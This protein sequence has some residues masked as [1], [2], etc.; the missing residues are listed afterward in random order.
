MLAIICFT[1]SGLP[2][3]CI[4]DAH[5]V[6]ITLDKAVVHLKV[7]P[8]ISDFCDH[9]PYFPIKLSSRSRSLFGV[10]QIF[11]QYTSNGDVVKITQAEKLVK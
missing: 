8:R 11:E 6:A 3:H 1:S 4:A 5:F 10:C 7:G 2:S 9:F